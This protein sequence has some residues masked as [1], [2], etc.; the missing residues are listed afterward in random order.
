MKVDLQTIMRQYGAG[1]NSVTDRLFYEDAQA[2]CRTLGQLSFAP[3]SEQAL[4]VIEH[5]VPS[6]ITK[7]SVRLSVARDIALGLEALRAPL[8]SRLAV[9]KVRGIFERAVPVENF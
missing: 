7:P 3:N 2:V 1:D 8:G 6:Q 4:P 9:E 5:L